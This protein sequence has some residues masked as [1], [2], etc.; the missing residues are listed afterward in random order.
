MNKKNIAFITSVVLGVAGIVAS[1]TIPEIRSA[2]GLENKPTRQSGLVTQTGAFKLREFG[3]SEEFYPQ[4]FK[5]PPNLT[6]NEGPDNPDRFVVVEQRSDGFKYKVE[7]A[8]TL[9]TEVTWSATGIVE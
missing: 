3:V 5:L 9:G 8:F 2:I 4:P 6:F 7:Y 1:I